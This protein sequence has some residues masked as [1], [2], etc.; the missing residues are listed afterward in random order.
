MNN[1]HANVAV[2][3]PLP[4]LLTVTAGVLAHFLWEP[5]RLFPE[6][7][8]GHTAGWPVAVAA[9]LLAF[10]ALMTMRRAGESPSVHQPT[11]SIVST[12]PYAFTRNPM[13]LSMTLLSA[14]VSLIFNT[15]WP[16]ILLPAPLMVIQYG[17]IHRE[18]R[19]LGRKFGDEYAQ[20][21]AR[22]RRWL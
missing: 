8:M 6:A 14:G 4:Y 7:W 16:V 3:P 20:Y 11:G 13:Y 21:R 15:F 10:W 2:L 1:D 19:Y 18:E 22:V 17:V 12:G 5:F 9:T